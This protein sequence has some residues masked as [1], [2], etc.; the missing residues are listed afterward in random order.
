MLLI[1]DY[2]LHLIIKSFFRT[3]MSDTNDVAQAPFSLQM[4]VRKE[5][6]GK[7]TQTRHSLPD[8]FQGLNNPKPTFLHQNTPDLS[9]TVGGVVLYVNVS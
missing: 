7:F 3:V 2:T 4:P 1:S 8:L 5:G 9:N 6:R